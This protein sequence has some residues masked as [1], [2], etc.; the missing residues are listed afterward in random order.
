MNFY[1]SSLTIVAA[2]L[3]ASSAPTLARPAP[4][5][6]SAN[7]HRKSDNN[8]KD[9]M[10]QLVN[11]HRA[12][13]DLDPVCLNAKLDDAAQRHS[14][15]MAHVGQM[16]HSGIG[17]GTLVDRVISSGYSYTRASE[18]IA[19]GQDD[20]ADVVQAWIDSPDHNKNLLDPA[21]TQIGIG[22]AVNPSVAYGIY[23]TQ[24]F[25]R[26]R[27]G[28]DRCY[29][30]STND[31][32]SGATVRT[33]STPAPAVRTFAAPRSSEPAA[34]PAAK[35]VA[36]TV[37]AK[38]TTTNNTNAAKLKAFLPTLLKVLKHPKLAGVLKALMPAL[39]TLLK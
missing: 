18:N 11:A 37:R 6:Q 26:S 16:E 25:G 31:A 39:Q 4:R 30:L 12:R 29:S 35:T 34:K 7:F 8:I 22:V 21:M 19:A 36:K 27:S 32:P 24:N 38:T 20:V 33:M 28:E 10:L 13:Y 9:E 1:A 5:P 3:L 15:H 14:D 23:W 2:V 17:D